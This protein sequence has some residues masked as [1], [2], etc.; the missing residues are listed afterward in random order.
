MEDHIIPKQKLN[1]FIAKN[2]K[3]IKLLWLE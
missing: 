3:I 1:S 2:F